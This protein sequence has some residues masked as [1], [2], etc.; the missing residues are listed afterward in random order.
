MEFT[1]KILSLGCALAI[2]GCAQSGLNLTPA[3]ATAGAASPARWHHESGSSDPAIY[4]F[5][6]PPDATTAALVIR[7]RA[8]LDQE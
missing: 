5:Q 6:G 7:W 1:R 2:A 8:Q 4:V 3:G